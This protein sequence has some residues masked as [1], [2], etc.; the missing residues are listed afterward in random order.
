MPS[1]RESEILEVI[2]KHTAYELAE[3]YLLDINRFLSILFRVLDCGVL[4][5]KIYILMFMNRREWTCME[6][7]GELR[8]NRT[9]I[10]KALQRLKRRGFVIRV[11]RTKW[12]VKL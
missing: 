7:A 8:R 2:R 1:K 4:S 9:N 5:A 11:S 10:Y 3:N 12:R 6:L